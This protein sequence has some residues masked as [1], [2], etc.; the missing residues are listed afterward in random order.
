MIRTKRCAAL[1]FL[2]LCLPTLS[3]C[4]AFGT[5]YESLESLRVV[6]TLGV[7][8]T[9]TGVRLSLATA[10]GDRSGDDA[11]CLSADGSTLSAAL[12]R[13]QSLSTEETLFCGHVRQLVAGE[14][15]S[16]V[17]FLRYAA[18]SPDL[19]LDTPLWLLRDSTAESLLSGAGSGSRGVTEILAAAETELDRRSDARAFTAGRIIRDLQRQGSALACVLEYIPSSERS[20]SSTQNRGTPGTA[21]TAALAGFAVVQGDRI[22]GYLKAEELLGVSLFRNMLGVEQLSLRDRNG[23]AAVL[24]IHEGGTRL[25]PVWDED[26]A[27]RALEINAHVVASL[28]EGDNGGYGDLYIDDLTARLESAV[29]EQLRGLLRRSKILRSDF[30]GLGPRVEE[31]SPLAFRRM[32]RSFDDVLPGL[33]ISLTVRGTL[34]H[35]YDTK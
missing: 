14:R 29:A 4:A 10:A 23:G 22:R 15:A 13:A 16:L 30:L 24:E 2:L 32:G 25:R 17:P 11:V 5:H 6:Q 21:R 8:G 28:V 9:D 12:G 7:D 1:L 33:E 31:A 20:D 34:Q 3:G 19:R 26:G 18:R 35:E 27:L